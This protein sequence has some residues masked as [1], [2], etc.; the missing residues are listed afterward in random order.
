MEHGVT[1]VLGASTKPHRYGRMAVESLRRHGHP[2]LAV[3]RRTGEIGDVPILREI[4][5]GVVVD[6]VTMYLNARNQEAYQEQ[7]LALSPRRIIFNPGAEHPE[8]AKRAE[9]QGIVTVEG[10]TLVMLSAGT[11]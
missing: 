3:G 9:A 7:L 11:Y 4:P 6:T 8:F 10:C 1:L 5:A 2:V